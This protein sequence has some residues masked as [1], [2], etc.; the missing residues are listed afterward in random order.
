MDFWPCQKVGRQTQFILLNLYDPT[1]RP[2]NR[3]VSSSRSGAMFFGGMVGSSSDGSAGSVNSRPESTPASYAIRSPDDHDTKRPERSL[4]MLRL[5]TWT[6]QSGDGAIMPSIVTNGRSQSTV[7]VS[8]VDLPGPV[9]PSAAD[10]ER[11]RPGDSRERAS[12]T[13]GAL[14]PFSAISSTCG[15]ARPRTV[16]SETRLECDTATGGEKNRPADGMSEP[17]RAGVR[18][19]ENVSEYLA[20]PVQRRNGDADAPEDDGD[21]RDEEGE[22]RDDIGV[23]EARGERDDCGERPLP[24]QRDEAGMDDAVGTASRAERARANTGSDFIIMSVPL[25]AWCVG[26]S[27]G[28]EWSGEVV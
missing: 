28:L 1:T 16:S 4:N 27:R 3:S 25:F 20:C 6:I 7:T 5:E 19:L 11:T 2:S 8:V 23:R 9:G 14:L 12:V 10:T 13:S 18:R 15:D 24:D 26:G 22:P 17:K 21:D